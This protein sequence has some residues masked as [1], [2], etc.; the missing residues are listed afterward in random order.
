MQIQRL[1]GNNCRWGKPLDNASPSTSMASERI[2]IRAR[3]YSRQPLCYY[4]FYNLYF[5]DSTILKC[6]SVLIFLR[7]RKY[8]NHD[9]SNWLMLQ[10]IHFVRPARS[11]I[12]NFLCRYIAGRK[13]SRHY[14]FSPIKQP[15]K[16][17]IL[18]AFCHWIHILW[19]PLFSWSP[20]NSP[21]MICS[22]IF[23]MVVSLPLILMAFVTYLAESD[24][25]LRPHGRVGCFW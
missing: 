4:T 22:F 2:R 24:S 17:I 10:S 11:A 14:E 18:K 12:I 20:G 8:W 3:S 6:S 1:E 5:I 13:V 23:V 9:C 19:Y 25:R 15:K 16:V 21:C 7:H